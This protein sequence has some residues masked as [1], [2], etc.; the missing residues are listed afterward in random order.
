M[1]EGA[2]S[3]PACL[4]LEGTL[5]EEHLEGYEWQD[6]AEEKDEKEEL[7]QC[8][9]GDKQLEEPKDHAEEPRSKPGKSALEISLERHKLQTS[10]HQK[11]SE[12][13]ST[14][15]EKCGKVLSSLPALYAHN[16]RMHEGYRQGCISGLS[17]GPVSAKKLRK[18]ALK[19]MQTSQ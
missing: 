15:C 3:C 17:E 18:T 6:I 4:D 7:V 10:L 16:R 2:T 9:E 19:K 12:E 1:E 5:E 8:Q 14:E 13:K 11:K